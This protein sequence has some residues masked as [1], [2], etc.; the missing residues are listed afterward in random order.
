MIN[1]IICAHTLCFMVRKRGRA[2]WTAASSE[3]REREPEDGDPSTAA[4]PMKE[5]KAAPA[6]APVCREQKMCLDAHR[7]AERLLP[8]FGETAW[9]P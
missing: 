3:E 4:S 9:L 1:V 6:M 2:S 8:L 7:Q 5:S